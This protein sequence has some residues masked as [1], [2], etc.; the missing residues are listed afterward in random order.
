[1]VSVDFQ[2]R[3]LLTASVPCP[4]LVELE[5]VDLRRVWAG[6]TEYGHDWR[7]PLLGSG[8]HTLTAGA[9]GAGKDAVMWCPLVSIAPAIRDGRV[10][11]SGIDPKGMEPRRIWLRVTAKSQVGIVLGDQA[12]ERGGWA[13]RIEE[14]AAGVGYVWGEGLR[15]PLWVRAGRVPD[16][17]VKALEVFVCGGLAP[18]L[19]RSGRRAA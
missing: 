2:R 9:S 18:G 15:E 3:D 19:P 12:Y 14:S 7:V 6:R 8:S 4:D 16:E 17:A 13:N 1:M 10:R 11:V 5:R